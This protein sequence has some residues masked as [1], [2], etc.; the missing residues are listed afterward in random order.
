MDLVGVTDDEGHGHGLAQGAAEAQHDAADDAD[1]RIGKYHAPHH[2]PGRAPDA[3]GRFAEHRRNRFEHVAGHR[4]DE[5]QDHDAEDETGG[6]YADAERRSLEQVA[7]TR[8]RAERIDEERLQRLLQQRRQDEQ[9]PN[10]VND[11]GDARE[12]LDRG[13]DRPFQPFR[14]QFGNEDGDAET[15]R[16]ADHHGDDRGHDGAVDRRERAELHLDRV[17]RLRGQEAPAEMGKCRPGALDQDEDHGTE[18]DQHEKCE[19]VRRPA[20]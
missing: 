20:E 14:T 15:D 19:K 8:N 1:T 17:P 5:R 13:A 10:A 2:F 6:E 3:I 7:D 16:N 12:Q 4:G 9:T 11:A 18:K